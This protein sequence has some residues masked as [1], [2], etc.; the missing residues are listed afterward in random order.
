MAS[1]SGR[2]AATKPRAWTR[3]IIRRHYEGSVIEDFWLRL[4]R[5]SFVDTI[6][7][8]GAVFLLS[9]LP[10][11]ILVSSFAS[12]RIENDLTSH[13]GL[14]ARAAHIVGQLFGPTGVRSAAAVIVA[15]VLGFAGIIGVA[16]SM[17]NVYQQIFGMSRRHG[18]TN[19]IRL[20]AWAVGVCGW[21][22]LTSAISA[23]T[24]GLP[25]GIVIE[26]V[27]V[28]LETAAFFWWSIH[29]LLGGAAGWRTL[30]IPAAVTALFW[31]GLEGFA[32]LY[33]SSTIISDSKLYGTIGVVFSL[34]TW[35]I[36][37]AAVLVLGALVGDV[38]QVRTR[39]GRRRELP[40][41]SE[42]EAA[43]SEAAVPEAETSG[44]ET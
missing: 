25:M 34:L 29:L 9:A 33:F 40:P 32:A 14:N 20:V 19:I 23:A 43:V 24:K 21:L 27:V 3:P 26:A 5:L 15:G 31:I 18:K 10:F 42:A 7:A 6:T 39:K 37:I 22:G 28:L 41:R 12:H 35:F 8:F 44:A 30:V 36:A 2:P 13:M 38:V 16:S 1:P 4:K 17:Q 11:A